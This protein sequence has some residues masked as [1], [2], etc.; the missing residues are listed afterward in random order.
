M[1]PRLEKLL[2]T[3]GLIDKASGPASKITSRVDEMTSR[4]TAGMA[5]IAGGAAGLFATGYALKAMLGPAI[6]MDRAIGEVKSLGVKDDA[7]KMLTKTALKTSIALGTSATDI[8]RSAYD[9]QSAIAGLTNNELSAFTAASAVLAKGTKSDN[10]TIT[11]YMGTMYGIFKN[12]ANQMGKAEWVEML[13]GQTAS[14]VQMFKTTGAEMAGAFANLGAEANS[15]GIAM[16]EQMAVLGTLQATMSGS[17]AGTKYKAFL[18]GVGKAQDA[19]G[20]K[21][22]DSQG[23]MLPMVNILDTLRTKFG[24]TLD[25]AE[26]DALKKAFGSKEASGLIKLL[27]QDTGGLANSINALGKVKGMDAATKMAQAMVDPWQQVTAVG[28]AVTTTL[29]SAIQPVLVPFLQTLISGMSALQDYAGRFPRITRAVG[30]F[31]LAIMGVVAIVST[32]A[33]V[34][35]I[36][37]LAMAGWSGA[38]IVATGVGKVWRFGVALSQAALFLFRM[39]LWGSSVAINALKIGFLTS[40]PAIYAFG[41]ALLANPITWIVL[42]VVALVAAIALAVV[43][44]D[45]IKKAIMDFGPFKMLAG[46]IGW[47]IDLL[48]KV[49]GISIGADTKPGAGGEAGDS[50]AAAMR[51]AAQDG[52]LNR[53]SIVPPGGLQQSIA[54]NSGTTV[55]KMEINTTGGVNGYQVADEMAMA[56]G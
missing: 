6:E 45:A 25:V 34:S 4:A 15:S 18:A 12:T 7:L 54:N 37:S 30:I 47:I 3:V 27:M 48:N 49:P 9:I 2:F 28:N 11:N 14:A 22:T 24:D 42:G 39:S 23:K 36:A 53:A 31:I 21:F 50:G 10:A 43:H 46:Y 40:L 41:A 13:T 1:G 32:F 33:I 20:L 51:V 35:G 5:K 16:S 26:S 38:M 44:W 8:V 19:L 56:G 29:G 17:E 55:E 52:G